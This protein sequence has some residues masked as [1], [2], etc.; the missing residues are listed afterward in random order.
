MRL[1]GR[2]PMIGFYGLSVISGFMIFWRRRRW[3]QRWVAMEGGALSWF[4]CMNCNG[5]VQ[6]WEE[7]KG[8]LLHRF[9]FIGA[10]TSLQEI[11]FF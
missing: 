6:R 5:P 8:L 11:I 1:M 4:Q 7:F 3:T 2:N 10:G 9:R